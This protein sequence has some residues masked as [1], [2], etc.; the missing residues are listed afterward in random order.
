MTGCRGQCLALS[1]E[2]EVR[3]SLHKCLASAVGIKFFVCAEM[4]NLSLSP[5]SV[6]M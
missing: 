5:L 2:E 6:W 1:S 4:L 3:I